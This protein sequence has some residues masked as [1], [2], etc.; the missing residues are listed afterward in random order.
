MKLFSDAPFRA[1]DAN[2]NPLAGAK[3]YF[4][5]TGTSTPKDTYSDIADPPTANAN[6]VVADGN[7]LFA[8][9]YL[10][11][12]TAYKA[13]LKDSSDNTIQTIDPVPVDPPV[14]RIQTFVYTG[15]SQTYTPHAKMM[16]ATIECWGSG[17]GGG[18]A[19]V[20]ST[21]GQAAAGGAG[22]AGGYSRKTVSKSTVGTSQTVTVSAAGGGGSAG[23]NAGSAGGDTSV[24]TL[25]VARGGS[26][27]SGNAGGSLNGSS[28]GAGGVAG[29]GDIAAPGMDGA[30]AVTYTHVTFP[31]GGSTLVGSGGAAPQAGGAKSDG[32][33]GTGYGSGG[34][35]G[36]APNGTSNAAGGAGTTG[37]V[38][39][40]EFCSQ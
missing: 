15:G 5:E 2:G 23:N 35:G 1:V 19:V 39:I 7:G 34:G 36:I 6:P 30:S 37:L 26:A 17:G 13:I 18:G 33:N 28:G 24:G 25:C 38:I 8:P 11:N 32:G 10:A 14:I 40:T 29:T 21:A 9:I 22:G 4:Y 16:Y 31:R 27:G 12:G 20:A 3:L